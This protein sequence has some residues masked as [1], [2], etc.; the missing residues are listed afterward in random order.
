MSIKSGTSSGVEW[1]G[2]G[3]SNILFDAI[4]LKN[5]LPVRACIGKS[6]IKLSQLTALLCILL[7]LLRAVF[8]DS[9]FHSR[10]LIFFRSNII[11][12]SIF[13]YIVLSQSFEADGQVKKTHNIQNSFNQKVKY[14]Y[15]FVICVLSFLM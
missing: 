4:S 7:Y 8:N 2:N 13:V 15:Y 6:S 14:A 11:F 10:Q 5:Q 9:L 12:K 1:F 3:N